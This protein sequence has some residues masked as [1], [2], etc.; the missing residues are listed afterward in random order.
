MGLGPAVPVV[1][2]NTSRVSSKI[3]I[4]NQEPFRP[5]PRP[6]LGPIRMLNHS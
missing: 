6:E 3:G 5:G 2:T 4:G 1:V